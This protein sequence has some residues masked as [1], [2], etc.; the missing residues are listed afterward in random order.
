M[1][2]FAQLLGEINH[3]N[4]TFLTCKPYFVEVRLRFLNVQCGGR[5]RRR[6]TLI[7]DLEADLG[8]PKVS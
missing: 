8:T 5:I 7:W 3:T 2:K 6:L 4:E 1:M